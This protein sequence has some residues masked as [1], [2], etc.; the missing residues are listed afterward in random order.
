[1]A[2]CDITLGRK[3]PCKISV[4][5]IDHIYFLQDNTTFTLAANKVT[6]FPTLTKFYRYDLT[7]DNGLEEQGTVDQNTG[8]SYHEQTLTVT[9]QI[10]SEVL[11][12]ELALM[13]KSLKKVIVKD[14]NGNYKLMGADNG[15][16]I[17][18]AASTGTDYSGMNGYTISIVGKE[19]DM[20]YFVDKA[21]IKDA[22]VVKGV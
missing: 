16:V 5:G 10:Q 20:S 15:C 17:S 2:D 8:T 21:A 18:V 11:Q 19:K 13:Q 4:G 14:N 22:D 9:L 6:A 1:M 3:K 7:G 12:N